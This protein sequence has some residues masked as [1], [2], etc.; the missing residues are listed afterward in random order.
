MLLRMRAVGLGSRPDN[1]L[2]TYA[3]AHDETVVTKDKDFA[4]I[5]AYP[6]PHS[7][8][9]IAAVPD[10]ITVATFVQLLLDGLASLAGQSLANAVVT[11][12]PGRVRVRR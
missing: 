10:V 2:W 8:I 7:G 4:D 11:I 6:T 3:Q 1:E 9:V 5:R 12:A